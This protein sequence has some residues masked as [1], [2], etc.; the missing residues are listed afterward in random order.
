[1]GSLKRSI[2][3]YP[4]ARLSGKIKKDGGHNNECWELKLT[5]LKMAVDINTLKDNIN[6][7]LI[8]WES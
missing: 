7:M 1:M 6:F 8:Y 3:I 5:K 2:K 4:L